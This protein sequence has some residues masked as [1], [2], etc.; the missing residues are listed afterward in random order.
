[1]VGQ[2]STV[3]SPQSRSAPQ[4]GNVLSI[5]FD[6][7][8]L[9]MFSR[10]HQPSELPDYR[11]AVLL[12]PEPSR[13]RISNTASRTG[14]ISGEAHEVIRSS[15]T[16]SS[17]RRRENHPAGTYS[18]LRCRATFKNSRDNLIHSAMWSH[19]QCNRCRRWTSWQSRISTTSTTPYCTQCRIN[20]TGCPDD[21]ASRFHIA[22]RISWSNSSIDESDR[23]P[24]MTPSEDLSL[25]GMAAP[26]ITSLFSDNSLAYA[27][28]IPEGLA[29]YMLAQ[30]EPSLR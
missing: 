14:P 19:Q 21:L 25:S 3:A 6:I 12:A 17:H 9:Q 30:L 4:T 24:I 20:D 15:E 1:M 27:G 5:Q 7:S 23:Y 16:P 18:C 10:I 29:E 11:L 26:G 2:G 13:P 22:A 8:T 28:I